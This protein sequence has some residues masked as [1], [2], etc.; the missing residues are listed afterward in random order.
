MS[1]DALIEK[2]G[3]EI[4][5]L[6]RQFHQCP[7]LSMQE[8]ETTKKIAAVLEGWGIPYAINTEKNT[9]LVATIVGNK[10][11][12]A[13]A[14]R[15][16]IDALPVEE[17]TGLPFASKNKGVMHACGH[18]NH[19][20]VL[21]GAARMLNDMKDGIEGTVYL[22][23]QP[24]EETGEGATYMMRF[25]DWF[26]KI[27]AIFGGHVFNMKPQGKIGIRTGSYMSATGIFSIHVHGVQTHGSQPH[28]GI[29]A[30]LVGSAIVM[31]LQQLVAR[32]CD[33]THPVVVT[34]GKFDGGDRWNIVGG[35]AVLEGTTRYFVKED[36]P[37]LESWIR[38]VVEETAKAYGATAELEYSLLVPPTVNDAACADLARKAAAEVLGKDNVYDCDL[39]MVGEDFAFYQQEKPGCY[40]S[41]S[42]YNEDKK[43]TAPNHS[44][45]F[46]T[47][48]SVLPGVSRVYAQIAVD[49]LKENK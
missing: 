26:E 25:G 16:D 49:W 42:T 40:M 37:K 24:A 10:P 22:V 39:N 45:Y 33:P 8:V 1:C 3:D 20:A 9:G 23:F 2:Y 44:N 47:D 35:E 46:T 30:V 7:E 12:K 27:G 14:L 31:N 11:G 19:I 43:A 41:L 5:A 4:I 13:V 38:T 36:G 6:R 34:V 32:R 17:A 48:D 28:N 29:D 21:L 18:D 15:A